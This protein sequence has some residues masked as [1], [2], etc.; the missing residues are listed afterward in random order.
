LRLFGLASASAALM[1]GAIY[2]S[3][4]APDGVITGCYKKSGGALRVIDTARDGCDRN[5]E[6]AISWNQV[7]PQGPQGPVGPQG[8]PGPTGLTGPMGP[9]GPAGPAGVGSS[10][11]NFIGRLSGAFPTDGQFRVV[12]EK[13]VGAGN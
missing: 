8:P 2:A 13:T 1:G 7:G 6:Q 4:P 12:L 10:R 3:I 9:T 11:A 5:I